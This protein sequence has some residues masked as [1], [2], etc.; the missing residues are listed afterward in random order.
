MAVWPFP[1]SRRVVERELLAALPSLWRYA[2]RLERDDVAADD[3]LQEAV[4]K[5]LDRHRQLADPG[6][7]RA[8]MH[9]I[10]WT[11]FLNRRNRAY[12]R[13]EQG[14]DAKVVD[15]A[16]VRSG[17]EESLVRGR[18]RDRVDEALRQLPDGQRDAILL[19]DGQGLTFAEAGVV[20]EAPVGTV[21]SRVARG[22]AA[23]RLL[24]HDV[25]ADEGV[26]S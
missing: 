3:L 6:A 13:R 18:I 11:T 9:R 1:G 14:D 23:L 12:R 8:W 7:F 26:I 5:A 10:V 22:R 16:E 20:L 2:R 25:A 17:P 21:A 4:A 24:L 15:L 19:V